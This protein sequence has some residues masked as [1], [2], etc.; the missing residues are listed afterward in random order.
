[1]WPLPVVLPYSREPGDEKRKLV[2]GSLWAMGILHVDFKYQQCSCMYLLLNHLWCQLTGLRWVWGQPAQATVWPCL[3]PQQKPMK[4][5]CKTQLAWWTWHWRV[6]V[7]Y[8]LFHVFCVGMIISTQMWACLVLWSRSL[9]LYQH[10]TDWEYEDIGGPVVWV[11]QI[12]SLEMSWEPEGGC[13]AWLRPQWD[14]EMQSSTA[15][16]QV[17]ER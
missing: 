11:A 16:P 17:R 13:R 15:H 7:I 3:W 4:S 8:M 12:G 1:M 6:L 10:T 9:S 14:V 2:L 5:F